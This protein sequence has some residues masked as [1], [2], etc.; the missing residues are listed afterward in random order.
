MNLILSK[1]EAELVL[2]SLDGELHRILDFINNSNDLDIERIASIG[3]DIISIKTIR[4]NIAMALEEPTLGERE[5]IIDA[6]STKDVE[7]EKPL[8]YNEEVYT[9]E[10]SAEE[11]TNE[12]EA[13]EP[14]HYKKRVRFLRKFLADNK[15]DP[16][17][18]A[19]LCGVSVSTIKRASCGYWLNNTTFSKVVK[20]LELNGEQVIEFRKSLTRHQ[21]QLYKE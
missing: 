8:V 20:G 13:K 14:R 5:R 21:R 17:E 4:S 10:D 2:R 11:N 15:L 12:E 3:Q 7:A 18:A 1:N 16:S 6:T 19:E 9:I